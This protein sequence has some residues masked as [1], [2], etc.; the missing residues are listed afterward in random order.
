MFPRAMW[1]FLAPYLAVALIIA[2]GAMSAYENGAPAW[3]AY[4]G[5]TLGILAVLPGYER[6][7]NRH[8]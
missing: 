3:V 2:I 4:V 5:L 1:R 6:W 7:E 8:R